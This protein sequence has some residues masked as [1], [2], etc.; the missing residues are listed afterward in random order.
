M[1]RARGKYILCGLAALFVLG[2][3][4]R[5]GLRW[6]YTSPAGTTEVWQEQA[7][8]AYQVALELGPQQQ[9]TKIGDVPQITAT[10]VNNGKQTVVL[11]EP[12]DGS[13]DGWRTPRIAWSFRPGRG[14]RMR[15][16]NINAL[17]ADEVFTLEP[18]ARHQMSSWLCV[19]SFQ[20]MRP[21]VYKLAM[22][23]ANEPELHW[24]GLPLGE[25][26]REAMRQVSQSTPLSVVSNTIEI[27]L[28]D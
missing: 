8:P 26:D 13:A 1:K 19:P 27:T 12:G 5:S 18:G 17:K 11:V 20:S 22:K 25:H 6:W 24:S 21:G 3:G 15:C 14:Q 28:T 23:Y 2:I 7:D 9:Q 10:L 16:G 4:A